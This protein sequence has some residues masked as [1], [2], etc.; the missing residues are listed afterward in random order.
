MA[1][2]RLALLSPLVVIPIF[3]ASFA[4]AGAPSDTKDGVVIAAFYADHRTR[5]LATAWIAGFAIAGLLVWIWLLRPAFAGTS[6][7][8]WIAIYASAAALV[9]VELGTVALQQ[10][11][12]FIS[13]EPVAGDVARALYEL[14]LT[15]SYTSAFA[16]AVFT[17]FVAWAILKRMS[18]L[19]RWLGWWAAREQPWARARRTRGASDGALGRRNEHR[20]LPS[21]RKRVES[22]RLTARA[23]FSAFTHARRRGRSPRRTRR[24]SA[25]PSPRP[26]RPWTP[27]PAS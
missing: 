9:G 16:S 23:G 19:P 4:V 7:D 8:L 3:I 22:E 5:L 26:S 25:G 2:G 18:I 10:T 27:A 14:S 15:F 13:T 24:R 20:G 1:I 21:T 12:A 17:A 6:T 11:L